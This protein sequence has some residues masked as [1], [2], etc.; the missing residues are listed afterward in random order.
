MTEQKA[1]QFAILRNQTYY[2]AKEVN[3]ARYLEPMARLRKKERGLSALLYVFFG[4]AEK[5]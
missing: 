4:Q 2:H 3:D 1:I 5:C